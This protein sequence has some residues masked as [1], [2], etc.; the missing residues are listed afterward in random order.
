MSGSWTWVTPSLLAFT[1]AA[2]V[3]CGDDEADGAQP[4]GGRM[5][6]G[7]D[8]G[9]LAGR[10]GTSGRGGAG[11]GPSMAQCVATA[12][13]AA[14]SKVETE[15]V[16]CACEFGA[17]AAVACDA[18]CW[19]LFACYARACSDVD[20]KD[21]NAVAGCAFLNCEALIDPLDAM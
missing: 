13:P 3:G 18:T 12:A 6:S 20:V 4:D 10:G 1:L 7:V 5:D 19:A 16:S 14:M 17:P 15:C 11:G 9:V 2:G 21:M 8:G